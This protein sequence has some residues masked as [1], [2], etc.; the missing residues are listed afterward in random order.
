MGTIGFGVCSVNGRRRVPLPP[1]RRMAFMRP[2]I[3]PDMASRFARPPHGPCDPHGR[4]AG[5]AARTRYNAAGCLRAPA[6]SCALLRAGAPRHESAECPVADADLPRAATRRRAADEVRRSP[7]VRHP[8]GAR[9]GRNL[10]PR[11]AA[12]LARRLPR[13]TPRADH[14]ARPDD[15]SDRG[16]A[17][18]L[19]SL[20]LTRADG[21]GARVDGGGDHRTRA[22]RDGPPELRLHTWSRLPGLTAR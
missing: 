11:L 1:A 22:R 8:E 12:G 17:P 4:G 14:R 6:C 7:R 15:R 21:P 10:W 2:T 19:R 3:I 13:A 16:Q 18:D 5:R 9:R 20:H